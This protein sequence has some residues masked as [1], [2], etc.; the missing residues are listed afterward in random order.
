MTDPAPA[1]LEQ[2]DGADGLLLQGDK[3][4]HQDI[5]RAGAASRSGPA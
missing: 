3:D 2:A 5:G 1:A 4:R